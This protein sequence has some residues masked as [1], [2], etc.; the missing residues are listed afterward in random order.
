[1]EHKGK[2]KVASIYRQ[3]T[4]FASFYGR[5]KKT[6]AVHSAVREG[7][8]GTEERNGDASAND[9]FLTCTP[10]RLMAGRAVAEDSGIRG[11]GAL[12]ELD[13]QHARAASTQPPLCRRASASAARKCRR[14]TE[15]ITHWASSASPSGCAVKWAVTD[16]AL[17]SF[18]CVFRW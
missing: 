3:H 12:I 15:A 6:D 2:W 9:P 1:M 8:R 10:A 14:A 11:G 13:E 4:R 7:H 17:F 18:C 16:C 5:T